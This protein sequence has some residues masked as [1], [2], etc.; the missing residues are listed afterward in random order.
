MILLL[1]HARWEGWATCEA[2]QSDSIKRCSIF[3]NAPNLRLGITRRYSYGCSP[4]GGGLS[5]AK[6][7]INT[8]KPS[9][10]YTHL[11]E[12][13]RLDL[14]VE[15]MVVGNNEWHELFTKDELAKARHRL[16]QYG[17]AATTTNR[18]LAVGLRDRAPD[19]AARSRRCA[20]S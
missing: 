4:I 18:A 13:G 15:A 16:K 12:R 9:E 20:R 5:A 11:Y 3:T 8:P 17:Y 2:Y 6:Y 14:T 10:G 7:L 1:A 19:T